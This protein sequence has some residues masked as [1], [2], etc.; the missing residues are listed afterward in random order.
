MDANELVLSPLLTGAP[1]EDCRRERGTARKHTGTAFATSGNVEEQ[2]R[3]RAQVSTPGS[4]AGSPGAGGSS[5]VGAGSPGTCGSTGGSRR[6]GSS[7]IGSGSRG[8]GGSMAGSTTG[9]GGGRPGAGGMAGII[10][11][12]VRQS[13]RPRTRVRDPRTTASRR[14]EKRAAL[15]EWPLRG[16]NC[17]GRR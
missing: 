1:P 10:A 8:V 4:R 14:C 6:M 11:S 15:H 3:P 9:G 7:G 2:P 17:V 12:S 16:R 13:R 5:M